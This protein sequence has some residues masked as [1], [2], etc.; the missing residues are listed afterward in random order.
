MQFLAFQLYA[1]LASFGEP[2]VGEARPSHNYPGRSAILGLVGAALGIRRDEESA[3][4]A[5]RD[6][7]GVSVA[8]Y[9]E[10]SLLRDYHTTQVPSTTD[11]K[12]R[13]HR[14]R[15][16]ELAIP[17][18]KLNTILSTRDYRQDAYSVVLVWEASASAPY[19]LTVLRDAL[20][21]PK[22]SLYLGR[23]SCPPAWPLQAQVVDGDTLSAALSATRFSPPEYPR[24]ERRLRRLSWQD[25]IDVGLVHGTTVFTVP[26]KDEPLSRRRWQFGDRREF[27]A[28]FDAEQPRE[29]SSS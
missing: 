23:K 10:G 8:V 4:T 16:D 24:S 17:K 25:G 22:F 14:T 29:E 18:S 12:R 15:A 6:A 27:V 1:P 2:A 20:T 9:E 3:Q 11:L 19:P 21:T 26:R 5:L 28:L 13:P 7:Y